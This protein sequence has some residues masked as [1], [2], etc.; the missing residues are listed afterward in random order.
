MLLADYKPIQS[1]K[2]KSVTTPKKEKIIIDSGTIINERIPN[3]S[4]KNAILTKA[5]FN[6]LAKIAFCF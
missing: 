5:L 3:V 1:Q 6:D 2:T 4:A